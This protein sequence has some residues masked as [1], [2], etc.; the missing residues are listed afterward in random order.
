MSGNYR[1]YLFG[2]SL[3]ASWFVLLSPTLATDDRNSILKGSTDSF[4]TLAE[5]ENW[6]AL[7][8]QIPNAEDLDQS[9]ADGM[10]ALHWS[11]Y[12]GNRRAVHDLIKYGANLDSTT[13]YGV[14][15]LH[16]ACERGDE[17]IASMLIRKGADPNLQLPG[18][19]TPLMLAARQGNP[20]IVS[21]LIAAGADVNAKEVR[22]QTALMWAAA[23]GNVEVVNELIAKGA[24]MER[25]LRS[26]FTAFLF[27]A[28]HGRTEVIRRMVEQGADVNQVMEPANTGGRNPRNGMSA[29]MLAV[30]SG[31]FETA[32][33]LVRLGADPNDQRSGFAPLHAVT[34][35]RKTKVGDDPAGDPPP[36]GSG[37]YHSLQFVEKLIQAGAD[38]N[39]RL[40]N[41]KGGR[42]KLNLKG[43]TPFL[44][45]AK[46]ADVPLMKLLLSLGADPNLHTEDDSSPLLAAT[47]VGVLA[48]GEEPGSVKEVES[49]IRLLLEE[50]NKINHVD[51]N[52][53]SVMHGAAYRNYP[54]TVRLLHELG[55]DTKI[56]NH[57]NRYGWT[58][59]MIASGKRPGSFKPS[60]ETI[61]ALEESIASQ[62]ETLIEK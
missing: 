14:S 57:K 23:E 3:V 51:K 49:A 40:K 19:E 56:W 30:E 15:P 33:E 50:G 11:V 43:A 59:V 2:L 58:P 48:V 39:L 21:Q 1:Q 27:A 54:E 18:R 62:R 53:E 38:P 29:L 20:K 26:G 36:R 37:Q 9:Q 4:V 31:H 25:T 61:A 42:A 17:Q 5:K 45:A 8:E 55:A 44:M 34:W 35:V 10:T 46:T 24:D 7:K 13:V 28:R 16:I 60:P 47:G 41:G 6:N 32:L 22:G 52:G 12:H